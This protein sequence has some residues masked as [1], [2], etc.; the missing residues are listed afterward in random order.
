MA[1]N[2][3]DIDILLDSG[4]EALTLSKSPFEP[5]TRSVDTSQPQSNVAE[6]RDDFWGWSAPSYEPRTTTNR[7]EE[8]AVTDDDKSSDLWG[9][10][11]SAPKTPSRPKADKEATPSQPAKVESTKVARNAPT[12]DLLGWSA[13]AHQPRT[14]SKPAS[15]SHQPVAVNP[16]AW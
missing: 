2:R 5:L 6:H 13:P 3:V 11:S 12:K 14:I 1:P 16:Y 7:R 4:V 10:S 9:W 8:H 15:A